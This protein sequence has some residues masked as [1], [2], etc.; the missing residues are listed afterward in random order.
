MANFYTSDTHFGHEKLLELDPRRKEA[1]GTVE[2]MNETLIANW[3]SVVTWEDVVFILGDVSM[4]GKNLHHFFRLN[5]TKVLI[6]GNHDSTWGGA[7]HPYKHHPSYSHYFSAILDFTTGSLPP[8]KKNGPRLPVVMSHFPYDGDHY[9]KDRFEQFRLRD[10]GTVLLHGHV[11]HLYKESYS[12]KGTPQVN[13]GVDVWDW[14]PVHEDEL[15]SFIY[16]TFFT[17]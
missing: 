12:N 14:A 4:H 10:E 16:A 17:K 3:N 11:H 7:K 13:V 8:A 2:N 15:A 5:G 6:N 9:D 1:F